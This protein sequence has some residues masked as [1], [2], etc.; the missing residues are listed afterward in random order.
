MNAITIKLNLPLCP[1]DDYSNRPMLY[2]QKQKN[3]C[4]SFLSHIDLNFQMCGE[5]GVLNRIFFYCQG[6][7]KHTFM[8]YVFLILN[9]TQSQLF[10][11]W[12]K[13]YFCFWCFFGC[14]KFMCTDQMLGVDE[15]IGNFNFFFFFVEFV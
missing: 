5:T 2:I 11:M 15:T 13:F 9:K 3:I 14:K 6:L 12:P 1:W 10:W 7:Q 8:R 4:I